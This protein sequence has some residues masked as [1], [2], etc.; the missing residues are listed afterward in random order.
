MGASTTGA[1]NEVNVCIPVYIEGTAGD[2]IQFEIMSADGTDPDV[3][4]GMFEIIYL[5]E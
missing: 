2:A 5:H 1:N 3:D 4:D